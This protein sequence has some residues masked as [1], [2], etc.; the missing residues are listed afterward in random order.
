VELSSALPELSPGSTTILQQEQAE[1][2]DLERTVQETLQRSIEE[3]NSLT[4]CTCTSV[5]LYIDEHGLVISLSAKYFFDSGKAVLRSEVLPI[6]GQI[7]NILKPVDREIR[8]E[9]HT[10]DVP[11]QTMLYPL[12]WELSAARAAHVV[13]Y[14]ADKFK[15]PPTRLSAVG[16]GEFRPIASNHTDGGRARNR[17][18]DI[19]VLSRKLVPHLSSHQISFIAAQQSLG[20]EKE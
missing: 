10:D 3:K 11:I 13:K 8:I 6:I 17:R 18:V 12:H 9:G 14:L 20:L 16:Y 19:V 5:H 4:W 15:L 7:A 1:L 2:Q